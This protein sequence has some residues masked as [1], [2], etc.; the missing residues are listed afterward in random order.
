[1]LCLWSK[2]TSNRHPDNLKQKK[3][4]DAHNPKV[5]GSNPSPETLENPWFPKWKLMLFLLRFQPI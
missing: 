1:M 5:G 4:R 3:L 2:I